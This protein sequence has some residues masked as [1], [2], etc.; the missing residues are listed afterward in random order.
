M[1][2]LIKKLELPCE[3]LLRED[4]KGQYNRAADKIMETTQ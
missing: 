1:L 4:T 3:P 2:T